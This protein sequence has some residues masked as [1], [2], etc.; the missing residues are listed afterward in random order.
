MKTIYL[1]TY[2]LPGKAALILIVMIIAFS[3]VGRS[4]NAKISDKAELCSKSDFDTIANQEVIPSTIATNTVAKAEQKQIA[5]VEVNLAT[6]A[7]IQKASLVRK[8]APAP[9]KANNNGTEINRAKNSQAVITTNDVKI[10]TGKDEN[11]SK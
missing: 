6:N 7:N 9:E 3:Q 10:K 2:T 11:N 8:E 5:S 1:T 4:Q